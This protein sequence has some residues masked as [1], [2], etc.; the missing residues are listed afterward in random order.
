MLAKVASLTRKEFLRR[1]APFLR[2]FTQES[3]ILVR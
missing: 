3:E 2:P 1:S